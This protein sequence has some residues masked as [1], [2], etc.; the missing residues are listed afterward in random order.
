M[1]KCLEALCCSDRENNEDLV[2]VTGDY[3]LVMDGSTNLG[4]YQDLPDARW[5]VQAFADAFA[6][7]FSKEDPRS[8]MLAAMEQLRQE[9]MAL[10]GRDPL[11]ETA[12]PSA[13]FCLAY[14]Q[15]EELV[16]A[17]LGDCTALVY[18][19]AG[20]P[21]MLY[22]DGVEQADNRVL[23][24]M[25]A[26]SRQE[27]ISVARTVQLPRIQAMLRENRSR[28]NT[29]QGYW[30]LSF[31]PTAVA[32]TQL[33]RLPKKDISHVLLFSDGFDSLRQELLQDLPKESLQSLYGRIYRE[34]EN[35]PDFTRQPRFKCHDDAS[36]VLLQ[37][38]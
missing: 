16:I 3:V 34:E 28:M 8:A 23:Q 1:M 29:P 19:R 21:Q 27:G 32:H 33:V 38:D 13:S 5:F 17:L 4:M 9:Y 10:T 2:R 7:Y 37:I 31:D 12:L 20:K 26:L 15:G 35:D 6:R 24:Q 22:Q 30:I 36:C 14:E 18:P 11:L 25:V